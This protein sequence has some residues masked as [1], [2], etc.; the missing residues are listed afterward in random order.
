M[1][2]KVFQQRHS[3]TLENKINAWLDENPGIKIVN[4]V[5]SQ[6]RSDKLEQLDT[7]VTVTVWYEEPRA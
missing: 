2:V 5:Q 6:S 7:I 3:G 4:V 1:K